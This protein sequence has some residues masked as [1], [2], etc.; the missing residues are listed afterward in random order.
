MIYSVLVL[1]LATQAASPEINKHLEAG[2]NADKQ[3]NVALAISEFKKATELAPKSAIAFV[4]LGQAYMESH[5]YQS[6]IPVLRHA[7]ELESNLNAAHQ[8]LGYA[9]LAQGYAAAAEAIPHLER[10]KEQGA[11]GIAQLETGQLAE[12]IT[13]PR[14]A[15]RTRPNDQIGRAHV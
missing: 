4:D 11:L 1:W 7:V 10:A 8:L 15:L 12:A 9:L 5:D 13:N 2:I 3:G 14:A 6:A